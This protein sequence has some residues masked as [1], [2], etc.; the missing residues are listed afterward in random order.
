ML[1]EVS[2]AFDELPNDAYIRE[3]YILGAA[4][5]SVADIPKKKHCRKRIIKKEADENKPPPRSNMPPVIPVSRST[6]RRWVKAGIAPQPVK[7]S[8]GVVA[9]RVG[10]LREWLAAQA[11]NI[12]QG[13]IK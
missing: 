1:N 5:K 6:W 2:N 11:S 3:K 4:N 7:L 12:D 10:D 13:N 9:W 8:V